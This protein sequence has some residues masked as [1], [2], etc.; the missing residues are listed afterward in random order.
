MAIARAHV[1]PPETDRASQP[2]GSSRA[3]GAARLVPDARIAGPVRCKSS[4]GSH[5]SAPTRL[6]GWYALRNEGGHAYL[7]K[8]RVRPRQLRVGSPGRLLRQPP[9][10]AGAPERGPARGRGGAALG[11]GGRA[12]APLRPEPPG[13]G[14]RPDPVL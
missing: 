1:V 4:P 2:G 7:R 3:P 13:R 14:R 6:P 11:R 10:A 12:R 5:P 8:A 9:A